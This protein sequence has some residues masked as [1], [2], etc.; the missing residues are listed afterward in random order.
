MDTIS[1]RKMITILY[2]IFEHLPVPG[3]DRDVTWEK[4]GYIRACCWEILGK[5]CLDPNM[6]R[7][8]LDLETMQKL[9]DLLSLEGEAS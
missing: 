4:I 5:A 3:E 8:D 9:R 2:R 7:A 6:T 1:K